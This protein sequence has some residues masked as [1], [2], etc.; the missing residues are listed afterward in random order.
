[1]DEVASSEGRS[2]FIIREFFANAIME[3][4]HI[5]YCLR[6]REL[7]ISRESIQDVL[8]IRPTTPH[9]SLQYNERREKLEPL[10]EILGGQ[11]NKKALH[12]IPFTPEMRTLAYI[13][14]FNLYPI[15]NLMNL[16]ALR[17]I[18]LYDLFTHMEI[19]FCSH[20]YHIF[21]KCITKRNSRLTLPF[22]SIVMSLI[23][24]AR[25]KNPSGLQVMQR[26]D[27]KW[28]SSA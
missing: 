15:K 22:P 11:L 16:L 8:E 1:M 18:F 14:I 27:S 20:I 6:G 12:T 21:I 23:L 25:V 2:C 17:T 7:S 10:M 19:D 24:R 4:D 13:M 9:T 26:E 28:T 3:G 5:N